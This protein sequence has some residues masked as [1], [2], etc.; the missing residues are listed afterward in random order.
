MVRKKEKRGDK[1]E[2]KRS[3]ATFLNITAFLFIHKRQNATHLSTQGMQ[4]T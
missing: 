3:E 1:S 2:T 4:A